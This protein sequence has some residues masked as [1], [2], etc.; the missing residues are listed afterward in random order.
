MYQ[1][2][3]CWRIGN[4]PCRLRMLIYCDHAPPS[5]LPK[6]V[7]PSREW[8]VNVNHHR[9]YCSCHLRSNRRLANYICRQCMCSIPRRTT[10]W[11]AAISP[12]G[13]IMVSTVIAAPHRSFC[14]IWRRTV[15]L[16]TNWLASFIEP[17]LK[18][19]LRRRFPFGKWEVL[20]VD[21]K[22]NI[23]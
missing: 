8:R 12:C 15:L 4:I 17:S 22:R 16:G 2:K 6:Q 14:T 1:G 20:K 21:N 19:S 7:P 13:C 18:I 9:Q 10:G 3:K 11:D 5:A 23:K